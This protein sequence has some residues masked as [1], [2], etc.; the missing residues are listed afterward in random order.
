M[1]GIGMLTDPLRRA[2]LFRYPL[3]W[4]SNA[5]GR[6][7]FRKASQ[8]DAA[9]RRVVPSPEGQRTSIRTLSADNVRLIAAPS[10]KRS[11][12]EIGGLRSVGAF[13]HLLPSID[14]TLSIGG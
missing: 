1:S 9:L 5:M 10:T 8:G 12:E 7:S 2:V 4:G 14:S 13:K 11:S 3:S 6:F